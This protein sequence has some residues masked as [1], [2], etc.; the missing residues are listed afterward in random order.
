MPYEGLADLLESIERGGDLARVSVEVDPSGELL[1][2][3]RRGAGQAIDRAGPALLFSRLSGHDWPVVTNL[4]GTE[5]RLLRGLGCETFDELRDRLEA[6]ESA[7]ATGMFDRLKRLGSKAKGTQAAPTRVVRTARC[8]QVVELGSDIDLA[9]LPLPRLGMSDETSV[10]AAGQLIA[11][12]PG[13]SAMTVLSAPAVVLGSNRLGI[14]PPPGSDFSRICA[15]ARSRGESLPVALVLGA[16]PSWNIVGE[17]P[18]PPQWDCLQ[19]AASLRGSPVELVKARTQA[20]DVAADAEIVLEGTINA[21]AESIPLENFLGPF[22]QMVSRADGLVVDVTAVTHRANPV[23]PVRTMGWP[24]LELAVI[25]RVSLR[26]LLP[27]AQQVV[28]DLVGI[29]APLS[30]GGR[31]LFVAIAK[32]YA[33]QGLQA[34]AALRGWPPTSGARWIVVVDEDVDL[35]DSARVWGQVAAEC[36]PT[37]DVSSFPG[38]A[39][40]LEARQLGGGLASHLVLDSTR[41]LPGERATTPPR[42]DESRQE[43]IE[44]VLRRWE[45]Y[46]LGPVAN[47]TSRC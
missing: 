34:A 46:G 6:C 4:F 29:D 26:L 37:R 47:S 31:T 38:A 18:L 35:S 44:R 9:A 21:T 1:E 22:G 28:A 17:I 42:D 39:D 24:W 32:R 45:E 13:E 8:Q 12:Q 10:L 19:Y 43:I 11:R 40:P 7:P 5:G 14:V 27:A 30:G 16:C 3:A 20:I 33:G 2:V 23:L 15:V 36:D 41:K 25:R